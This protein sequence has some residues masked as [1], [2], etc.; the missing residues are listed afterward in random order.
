MTG[1]KKGATTIPQS[2]INNE[3]LTFQS[4]IYQRAFCTPTFPTERVEVM[5]LVNKIV[6]SILSKTLY[7]T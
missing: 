6:H 2:N 3:I 4:M 1:R 7:Y 5:N